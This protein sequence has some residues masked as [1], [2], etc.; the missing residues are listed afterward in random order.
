MVI[1]YLVG[2]LWYLFCDTMR[3]PNKEEDFISKYLN[4]KSGLEKL[5]IS[6]FMIEKN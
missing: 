6:C 2:C 1:T 3:E 5:I 4:D